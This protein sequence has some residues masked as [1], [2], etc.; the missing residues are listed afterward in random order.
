VSRVYRVTLRFTND[1]ELQACRTGEILQH[2]KDVGQQHRHERPVQPLRIS[3]GTSSQGMSQAAIP[4]TVSMDRRTVRRWMRSG[5][6]PERKPLHRTSSIEE[7]GAYLDRRWHEGCH[8][9]TQLWREMRDLGFS[10]MG[11]VVRHWIQ[12]H[13]G[14]KIR[15]RREP[16]P[17]KPPIV[18][19]RQLAW[20]ILKPT[21]STKGYLDELFRLSPNIAI[22]TTLAREFFRMVRRR[23]VSAWAKWRDSA[24][25][26]RLASF[27][28]GLCRDEAAVQAALQHGAMA[29]LK[30]MCT[31]LS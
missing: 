15:S 8:N 9:A 5:V 13:Y 10:G 12:Q 28:R 19:S 2:R 31:G 16:I 20:H 18:S 26:S 6:F 24:L 27:A 22:T 23:D 25:H 3:G 7:Y 11:S 4:R 14:R 1:Q 17:P 29:Q 30:A 21:E